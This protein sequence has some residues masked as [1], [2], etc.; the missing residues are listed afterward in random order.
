MLCWA[1]MNE[2]TCRLREVRPETPDAATL[3]FEVDGGFVYR[4]G[5]HLTID[6]RQFAELAEE[7]RRREAERGRP[8]GPGYYSIASDGLDPT[9]LE[10]TVKLTPGQPPPLLGAHLARGL[11]PGAA[12]KVRGPGGKFGLPEA[13]PESVSGFIHLCAGSGAAPH[14]GMVRRALGAGWPQKHLV[15]IQDRSAADVLYAE[16]WKALQ[17]RYGGGLRVRHLYSRQSGE[18]VDLDVLR[19]ASDG[20]LDPIEAW[21]FI[22]GPV[23]ARPEGPGF[24][25]Q[26]RL[27][28]AA[29]GVPADR[30]RT[31]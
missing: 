18:R 3:R 2:V 5:Q 26:C 16:E 1:A 15:L 30:L 23:Q 17:A 22:C 4:A 27:L 12:V 6:P 28:L 29:A 25:E 14:R 20:F 8:M 21:A 13:P 19:R 31:E 9:T 11:R 24:V 10:I 7:I